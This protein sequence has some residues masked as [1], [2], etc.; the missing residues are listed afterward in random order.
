MSSSSDEQP[1]LE[2][3]EPSVSFFMQRLISTSIRCQSA[4]LQ[5][6]HLAFS[7]RDVSEAKD[8]YGSN[9]AFSRGALQSPGWTSACMGTRLC[10]H[11]QGYNAANTANAGTY[12]SPCLWHPKCA[13]LYFLLPWLACTLG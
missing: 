6:F 9:L 13:I 8:F 11:T 7:V 1:N 5:P 12:N 10:H 2:P 3:A 4:S